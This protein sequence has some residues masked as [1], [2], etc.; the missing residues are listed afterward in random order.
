MVSRRFFIRAIMHMWILPSINPPQYQRVHDSVFDWVEG[1]HSPS[2]VW[3]SIHNDN[4][5]KQRITI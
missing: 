3:A 5:R 1:W 4:G 2:I